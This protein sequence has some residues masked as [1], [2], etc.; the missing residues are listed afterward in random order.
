ME[1]RR[2]RSDP[3][4]CYHRWR[5]PSPKRR[6]ERAD[7]RI[8]GISFIELYAEFEQ[9]EADRNIELDD[10]NSDSEEEFESNYKVVDLGG[11]E[12]QANGI[13]EADVAEVANALVNQHS[14]VE[15]TFMR[16]LDLEA[17]HALKFPQYMNV[18]ELPIVVDGEFI[19]GMEFSSREAVI[20]AMKN[21]TIRRGVDYRVYESEP[22][23]FYAKC[24]QYD[25]CCDWLIRVSKMCKKYC[26]E[27]RSYN[28]SHTCTRAISRGRDI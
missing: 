15:P 6:G 28:G 27:I 20:K 14:F 19:V 12:D 3:W 7:E 17:M 21:Y 11:D 26:W 23:T 16:S 10:Y 13:M 1:M 8:K 25:A 24:T 18:A 2:R 22:M 5:I 9:S 4:R